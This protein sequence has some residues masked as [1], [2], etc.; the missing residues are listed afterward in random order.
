MK[1]PVIKGE[2]L[3]LEKYI[4]DEEYA[5]IVDQTLLTLSENLG[6]DHF[7]LYNGLFFK[8]GMTPKGILHIKGETK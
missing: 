4:N 8:K 2:K 6:I 5:E 7:T 3:N 1:T